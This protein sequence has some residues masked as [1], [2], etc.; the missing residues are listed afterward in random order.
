[1]QD[2]MPDLNTRWRAT[3]GGELVL[4]IG[5][6]T[7]PAQ[8]GNTG[9]SRKFKYGPHGHT[10]NLASRVQEA[11]KELRLPLLITG[12]TRAQLPDNFLTRRLGQMQLPG[13]KEPV[14]LYELQGE[15]PS[16]DWPA[17]SGP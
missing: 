14:L 6:N 8:V 17:L 16:S 7:G 9:C 2:E 5:I 15:T 10:V 3:V 12:P 13:V 1:M 4:G 11:T